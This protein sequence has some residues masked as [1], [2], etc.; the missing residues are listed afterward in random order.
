MDGNGIT[1][2]GNDPRSEWKLRAQFDLPY[3][4]ELDVLARRVGALPA[5]AVPAYTAVDL[6]LGWQATPRIELSL[7]AKNLLGDRHAEFNAPAV[8]SEFGRRVFLRAVFQL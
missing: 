2:L 6:R 8:A 3:R 5:P 7:L 4:L 1:A